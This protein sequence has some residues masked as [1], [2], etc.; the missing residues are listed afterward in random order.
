R[1]EG[2]EGLRVL[3]RRAA[4]KETS[5]SRR[6]FRDVEV[7]LDQHV[8]GVGQKN[9]SAR[10]V[11]D[12]VDAERHA[13]AREILLDGAKAAAAEGD[14]VDDSRIR[15]LRLVGGR[16]VVEMQHRM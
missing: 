8:V 14:V 16:N 5:T 7:E 15:P 9:L 3:I 10:A 11:R 2:G 13:F 4:E 1:R 12:L 6:L